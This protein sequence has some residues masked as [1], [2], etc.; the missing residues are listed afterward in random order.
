[1][2]SDKV[3]QSSITKLRDCIDRCCHLKHD[4]KDNDK[5]P[6]WDGEIQ[7]YNS[8][9]F[10][11]STIIGIT[12]IQV[13]G[14]HIKT[15]SNLKKS[16]I[17]FPVKTDDLR[18]F[19]SDG[20]II[21]F[22]IYIYDFDMYTIYYNALLPL[23]ITN[24]LK[25]AQTQKTISIP[26]T[27]LQITDNIEV[28]RIFLN[29]LNDRKKQFSTVTTIPDNDAEKAM[30]YSSF[31]EFSFGVV[32]TKDPF[33]YI[34]NHPIY[35]YGNLQYAQIPLQRIQAEEILCS[36]EMSV[37][38]NDKIHYSL[39]TIKKKKNDELLCFG[40]CFEI[41][42]A[43]KKI[44]FQEHGDIESRLKALEFIK[45]L[46]K[47][48]NLKVGNSSF[49]FK[50]FNLN[51]SDN[52]EQHYKNLIELNLALKYFGVTHAINL[53]SM[54]EL[55]EKNLKTLVAA[56]RN[57][58]IVTFETP[59]NDRMGCFEIYN[60][61]VFINITPLENLS[62]ELQ[63][64]FFSPIKN[65]ELHLDDEVVPCSIF[66][67][68]NQHDFETISN[69]DYDILINNLT[70]YPPN[71]IYI[72]KLVWLLLEMLRA[73]K[74]TKDAK[75]LNACEKLSKHLKDKNENNNIHTLNYL[76]C[77]MRKRSLTEEEKKD[78]YSIRSTSTEASIQLAVAILLENH[79]DTSFY[80]S[81]LS[82]GQKAEFLNYPIATLSSNE[83]F[84]PEV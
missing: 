51:N 64:A 39:V 7:A 48:K 55:S 56:F 81:Q 52:I 13:K 34:L 6:S 28:E 10:S 26:F 37:I 62:Y 73:F 20:G 59:I 42:T 65:C 68:L 25:I 24:W 30:M 70:S 71:K 15:S 22:V 69:F 66:C 18:N 5:T 75:L 41:S 8:T 83:E 2:N 77:I 84:K 46:K 32:A 67:I 53:D 3:E 44:K 16:E 61:R 76:Q 12:R 43:T 57:N 45:D 72:D 21:Y 80:F 23:D 33:N 38:I 29:F 1:M 60:L 82:E 36:V 14:K 74:T 40:G 17:T 35:I 78:L 4:I 47:Y 50:S 79:Q 49:V 11:I 54:D 31:K 19:L 27:E 58:G 63:S 9:E